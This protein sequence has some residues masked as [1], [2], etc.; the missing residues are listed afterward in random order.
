MQLNVLHNYTKACF[1]YTQEIINKD[2]KTKTLLLGNK[3]DK[4]DKFRDEISNILKNSN[5]IEKPQS[6]K[7]LVNYI[8]KFLAE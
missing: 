3:I 7:K 8:N 5:K 2:I 6:E 1:S 4:A